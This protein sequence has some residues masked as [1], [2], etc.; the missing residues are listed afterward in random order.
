M[1]YWYECMINQGKRYGT[2]RGDSSTIYLLTKP[3]WSRTQRSRER[4]GKRGKVRRRVKMVSLALAP[5]AWPARPLAP[6]SG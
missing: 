2:P 4:R 1:V 3:P 6:A 5:L